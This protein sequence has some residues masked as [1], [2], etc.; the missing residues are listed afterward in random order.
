MDSVTIIRDKATG[1]TSLSY[2]PS[3]QT[4]IRAHYLTTGQSRSFGFAQFASIAGASAF[5][6]P[7]FPFVQLPPPATHLNHSS[8]TG[9]VG[10]RSKIDFSQSAQQQPEGTQTRGF[11]PESKKPQPKNDGTRDIGS[12]PTPVL[13]LRL[14]D[15][16]SDIDE[17]AEGLRRA[18]GPGKTGAAGMKRILLVKD[19]VSGNGW[20][21]AFIEM[22][23]VE[24]SIEREVTQATISILITFS[25]DRFS[26]F[27]CYHEPCAPSDRFPNR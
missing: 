13:L 2:T 12:A 27:C 15:K 18:E 24:V 11:H 21:F 6:L 20:G 3:L 1:T 23:N 16:A 14:L 26:C 17:I 22:I 25:L 19:R 4:D 9:P 5:V 7:N 10:R 8:A